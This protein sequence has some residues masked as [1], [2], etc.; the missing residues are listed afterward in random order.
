[1]AELADRSVLVAGASG[2]L[3][4]P[5]ARLLAE[6]GAR[7][8]LVAR[9]ASRLSALGLDAPTVAVDLRRAGAA[10]RA[11]AAALE[12]HGELDGIVTAAGVVAFGPA[13]HMPDEVL[14]E[15]FTLNTL[16]P[17]RL[18]RAAAPA[19]QTSAAAGREPFACTISAV[20]AEQPVAGMAAYSASKAAVTAFDAAVARELRR[21]GIR[22][23]D[24]R[25][26]HTE[27]GLATRPIAG[28][29][30]ALPRGL[31]PQAVAQRIVTALLEGERDLPAASFS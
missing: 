12:A 11:V 9:D 10:E 28:Q 16:A 24:A 6:Q 21:A 22:V 26:P 17:V 1:M 3:G 13:L 14:V 8:T 30:P 4:A 20:V 29:A 18:L 15:L 2:G 31:D 7:L 23:L 25:P 27:T 19:L 5:V